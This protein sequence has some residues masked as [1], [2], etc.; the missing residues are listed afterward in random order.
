M[1]EHGRGLEF[2]GRG[3]SEA[4]RLGI[5]TISRRDCYAIRR[6]EVAVRRPRHDVEALIDGGLIVQGS[7]RRDR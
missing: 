4:D 1:P 5:N 3:E 7:N 6:A 2:Q